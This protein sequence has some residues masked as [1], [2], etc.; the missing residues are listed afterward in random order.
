MTEEARHIKPD[1]SPIE[2]TKSDSK[3]LFWLRRIGY[4]LWRLSAEL[5]AVIMGVAI[6]WLF[7]L[8]WFLSQQSLDISSARGVL[9]Q[10]FTETVAGAGVEIPSMRLD[11][12]PANDDIV[13]TGE[14][15]IINANDGTD[16]QNFATLQSYFPLQDVRHGNLIPRKVVLTGGV[17]SWV[18]DK[19]GR[20]RAG[21]GTPDNLGRLGPLWEGRRATSRRRATLDLDGVDTVEIKKARAYYINSTNGLAA[22]LSDVTLNVER[23]AESL[24]LSLAA[25]LAQPET[26]EQIPLLLSISTNTKFDTFDVSLRAEGLNPSV[27]GPTKGRYAQVRDLDAPVTLDTNFLYGPE[28]GLASADLDLKVEAGIFDRADLGREFEFDSIRTSA[29]LNAGD[30][31]MTIRQLDVI[32][33]QLRFESTGALTDLDAINDGDINSSP[34][35]DLNFQKLFLDARPVFEESLNFKGLDIA[36]RLDVDAQTLNMETLTLDR[37]SHKWMASVFLDRDDEGQFEAI[38][39]EGAVQGP[40]TNP[41]LLE[42][43][44]VK[45]ADGARRWLDRSVEGGVIDG[46]SFEADIER[47]DD[48][49]L[50]EKVMDMD[51]TVRDGIVKYI[52]TMT[53]L[54]NASGV[55]KITDNRLDFSLETGEIGDLSLLPSQ[56][57][58]PRLKPKGGDII[59]TINAN[60]GASEMLGL[61]NQ[62]PFKLADKYETDPDDVSGQ[63]SVSVKITRPLL[64]YFDQNRILYEIRGD[65]TDVAAPFKIGNYQLTNGDVSLNVDKSGL[66]VKGPANI[67]PWQT[68]MEWSETF[69]EGL[70][71]SQYYLSGQMTPDVLDKIGVGFREYID[72]TAQVDIRAT[73]S[74]ADIKSAIILADLEETEISI[75]EYW[76]KPKGEPGSLS[77]S[78]TRSENSIDISAFELSAPELDVRGQL[79]F[80]SDF[81][82]RE[83]VFETFKVSDLVDARLVMKPDAEREV[84]SANLDGALLDISSILDRSLSTRTSA[85]D[86]PLSL[87]ATL[88]ELILDPEFT[89]TQATLFYAHSGQAMT[90]LDLSADTEAGPLSVSLETDQPNKARTVQASF[91]DASQA[92]N[93]FL[94]INSLQGGAFTMMGNLPLPGEEGSYVGQVNVTDFKVKDA[95]ILAQLLSLGSLTGLFNTLSGEGLAFENFELPFQLSDGVLT[96]RDARVYGPALGMTGAGNIDLKNETVDLDGALVPAYTANSLLGDLPLIGDLLVGKEGEGIFALS[97][98]VA[99][100]FEATQITVNPLSAL[101]PGFLRGIFRKQRDD[102]P[103]V[104]RLMEEAGEVAPPTD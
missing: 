85:L 29:V 45:F 51:F 1:A 68:N 41:E 64:E 96:V 38:R 7:A 12:Y 32:A 56:I 100:P 52:S 82:L 9:G 2:H 4:R 47:S 31:E 86:V 71:P 104:E 8:S 94:G 103:E 83:L 89:T 36:G 39:A 21:L 49:E 3:T 67:G 73:G 65:F 15:I 44:P 14:N 19:N 40:L 80:R 66:Q 98:Q 37:G 13:F 99:G 26:E 53:P 72:G 79:A 27:S 48:G 62:P 69:D 54:T 6:V 63:G 17:V 84:L 75:G 34:F 87:S 77:A 91:P 28:S 78:V 92:A 57:Q 43:W 18:E 90:Q 20:I 10:L 16:L 5:S 23:Q 81:A 102:L 11:W 76:N 70:T 101:T 61:L 35:F 59:I 60:G 55:A 24:N 95:P 88:D 97:Y 46:L 93:A 22:S 33:P 58:I 42:V 50:V 25:N 74:G 30:A